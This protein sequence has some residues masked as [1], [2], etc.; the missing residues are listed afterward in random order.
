MI[1]SISGSVGSGKTTISKELSKKLNYK[2]INLNELAQKYKLEEIE[3][4]QTFDFDLNKLLEELEEKIKIEKNLIL[5]GHFAHFINPKLIDYLFVINR[6]LKDL[7]Q[8]YVQRKYNEEKIKDN[9]EVEAMNICFY[10]ALEE[11]YRESGDGTILNKN[12]KNGQVFTIEN[13]KKVNDCLNEIL[14]RI[15]N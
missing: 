7:K 5:E 2:L 4:L 14:E 10:E 11:G 1:I 9:L 15:K 13:K 12:I 8:V 6:D 3:K